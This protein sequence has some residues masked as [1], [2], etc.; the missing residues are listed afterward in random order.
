MPKS[1]KP[2]AKASPEAGGYFYW[3]RDPAVGLFAVL[4]LW[5]IYILLRSQLAPA[6]RN[7]AEELLMQQ[8][9]RLGANWHL[10]VSIAF[11]LLMTVAARSLIKRRVP[12]LRVLAVIALEGL[13]YG[14]MLGPIAR[15]MTSSADRLLSAA[16][17]N[18]ALAA[19]YIGSIGAGIFEELV[20]RFGLMSF[21][22]FL[23]MRAVKEWG[24]P[25]ACAYVFAVLLSALIFSWFHHFCGDTYDRGI[26]LF[27]AMA[28]VLLGM[29]MWTRGFGV[30]VYTHTAYDLYF[31]L[32]R[33]A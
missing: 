23:G 17:P 27:R 21:L 24:L 12:W 16:A 10:C 5:L 20:F 29:L 31:Y 8:F 26:F 1:R 32:N 2:D 30:C 3:S 13:V 25:R 18:D 6:E 19:D 28:G 14:I 9:S 7:G 15:A 11:A 33:M 4:P 22:V